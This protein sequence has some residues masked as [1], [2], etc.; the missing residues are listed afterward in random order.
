MPIGGRLSRFTDAWVSRG[1]SKHC[2]EVLSAGFRV[3]FLQ[4]PNLSNSPIEFPTGRE[5]RQ[6]LIKEAAE[7]LAKDAIDVIPPELLTPGFYSRLFTVPKASG[8]LRPVIDLSTL[9]K[10][11]LIPKFKM[12]TS[13]SIRKTLLRGDWTT[14]LDLK[15]A[16]FHIPVHPSSRRYMRFVLEGTTYQ[17]KALP[18]GLSPAPWIFTTVM[19]EVKT[20]AHQMGIK[21][22]QYLDDWL[23]IS[24]Q[25]ETTARHT[26]ILLNLCS[27]LGLVVNM[28]KSD[29]LPS[30]KFEFL[31]YVYDLVT[32]QVRPSRKNILKLRTELTHILDENGAWVRQWQSALGSMEAVRRLIPRSRM[33]VRFPQWNLQ[34]LWDATTDPLKWIPSNP[35][36]NSHLRWWTS[37][38]NV[39]KGERVVPLNASTTI[40]TDASMSGWGAHCE[41]WSQASGKWTPQETE[42]H[43][44]PLEML[45]VI[46]ALNVWKEDLS[47]TKVMIATDNT[48]VAAYIR[49]VGGTRSPEMIRLSKELFVLCEK[50][51]ITLSARHI[52]GKLNAVADSLSRRGQII[53]KE[54]TLKQSIVY[55]VMMLWGLVTSETVDL[56]ATRYT[57]RLPMFVSPIPDPRALAVDAMSICW[58]GMAIYA[59]PPNAILPVV[60]AKLC[61]DQAEMTLIAPLTPKATWFPHLMECC[62]DLPR[63]LPDRDD[64]LS[65]PQSGVVLLNPRILLDL[66]A[67]RLSGVPGKAA[68]FRRTLPS[69]RRTPGGNLLTPSTIQDGSATGFGV[70]LGALIRAVPLI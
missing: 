35:E 33:H 5:S 44:N 22:F 54:W 37:D 40:F 32:Y 29:L 49:N 19:A 17:F 8:G 63:Q 46:R 25:K 9:N 56:F 42:L 59:Y 28:K 41:D 60:L 24:G 26:Q 55:L 43:I 4:R 16:Y 11:L 38:L 57:A 50:Y 15:D 48:T 3:V 39:F 68:A 2:R 23:I 7:M 45:A 1:C 62:I 12:D 67:W 36:V 47:Y 27:E 10:F 58:S 70:C 64:L 34:A 14:S 51:Q 31:G 20:M 18:F 21:L 13:E 69:A 6:I 30:Q 52:A 53:S 65:Q 61:Q 66:H